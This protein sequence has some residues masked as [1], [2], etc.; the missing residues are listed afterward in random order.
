MLDVSLEQSGQQ[1]SRILGERQSVSEGRQLAPLSS[2]AAPN[3]RR[4]PPSVNADKEELVRSPGPCPVSAAEVTRPRSLPANDGGMMGA[5]CC[6][7]DSH[8][9]STTSLM[10]LANSAS[11]SCHEEEIRA[12][13]SV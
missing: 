8:W 3:E 11:P 1:I 6:H 7:G 5:A 9:L 2:A 10:S 13:N 12:L 4:F